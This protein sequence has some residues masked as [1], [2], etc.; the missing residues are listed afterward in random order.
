[1]AL[2]L[3]LTGWYLDLSVCMRIDSSVSSSAVSSEF[4]RGH[5]ILR[6]LNRTGDVVTFFTCSGPVTVPCRDGRYISS[7]CFRLSDIGEY[8]VLL[9]SDWLDACQ[10][11]YGSGMIVGPSSV[12]RILPHGHTWIPFNNVSAS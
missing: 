10:P 8:D 9:G 11:T 3:Q 1:M 7:L 6:N 4:A 5:N 12:E 2:V